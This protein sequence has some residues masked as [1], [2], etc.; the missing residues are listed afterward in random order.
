M[1]QIPIFRVVAIVIGAIT[2]A[3]L[4][5][6]GFDLLLDDILK[7]IIETTNEW[8]RFGLVWLEPLLKWAID[9]IRQMN[10]QVPDPLDHWRLIFVLLLLCFSA[11]VRETSA[12]H[13][14]VG[15]AILWVWAFAV[16]LATAVATGVNTYESVQILFWPLAGLFLFFLGAHA[17]DAMTSRDTGLGRMRAFGVWGLLL[18]VGTAAFFVGA[19]EWVELWQLKD[20]NARA[21]DL[22]AS[23]GM[24]ALMVV[25]V[26]LGILLVLFG[27]PVAS[28]ANPMSGNR[29]RSIGMSILAVFASAAVGIYA[30]QIERERAQKDLSVEPE[31]V[32]FQLST[33]N[34]K[35]VRFSLSTS[36]VTWA[37]FNRF[38]QEER[39]LVK[40][41]C[42]SLTSSG[43]GLRTLESSWRSDWV[44]PFRKPTSY[45]GSHPVVCVNAADARAYAKWLKEKTGKDYRLP[46]EEEWKLGLGQDLTALNDK[47]MC[48]RGNLWGC[49][50]GGPFARTVPVRESGKNQNGLYGM[51]GNVAEWTDTCWDTYPALKGAW[52]RFGCISKVVYGGGYRNVPSYVR[53]SARDDMYA[54]G[55]MDDIGFRVARSD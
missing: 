32:A 38:V 11:Y 25:F 30:S 55:R 13:S 49:N 4:A 10:I 33:A 6:T 54:S 47:E 8:L 22:V 29:G 14:T 20:I 9:V 42:W 1:R 43:G 3:E 41:R 28:N 26:L 15:S 19:V 12:S 18:L 52:S 31:M 44:Q 45:S 48:E 35:I 36:E 39:Y 23:P 34:G 16:A 17:L 5:R 46:T 21:F 40:G 7:V 53:S 2:I 37:E 24:L 50:W 51:I 27:L